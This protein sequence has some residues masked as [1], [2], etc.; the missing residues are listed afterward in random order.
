MVD[1][2]LI[3]A[4]AGSVRSHLNRVSEK[5]NVDLKGFIEDIDAILNGRSCLAW[6][7]KCGTSFLIHNAYLYSAGGS[8]SN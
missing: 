3:L 6:P 2:N 8:V 7:R 4:K 1:P 5:R